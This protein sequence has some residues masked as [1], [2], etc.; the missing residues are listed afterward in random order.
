MK[1]Y[2]M[3]ANFVRFYGENVLVAAFANRFQDEIT[4]TMCTLRQARC[5]PVGFQLSN[6]I[7]STL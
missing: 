5:V 7:I 4:F 6:L 3:Q 2:L 1:V